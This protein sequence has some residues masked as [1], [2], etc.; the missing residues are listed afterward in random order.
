MVFFLFIIIV[1]ERWETVSEGSWY[2]MKTFDPSPAA[3]GF[4]PLYKT[5]EVV[6]HKIMSKWSKY[7]SRVCYA[8]K[9]GKDVPYFE[10]RL[11][12]YI[13]KYCFNVTNLD[14]TALRLF[15]RD[16]KIIAKNCKKLKRLKLNLNFIIQL[17]NELAQLFK[18]NKNLEDIEINGIKA[19]CRSL[20]KLPVQKMKTM[21][22]H[23]ERLENEIFSQV[24]I[25]KFFLYLILIEYVRL[26]T[27]YPC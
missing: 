13:S 26:G 4:P 2:L 14:L 11:S 19:L 22:L 1:C 16:I 20:L 23:C 10:N 27:S 7:I 15:P 5:D 12:D 17:D 25:I 8:A 24:S 9:P 21:I 18:E 6:F 3:W